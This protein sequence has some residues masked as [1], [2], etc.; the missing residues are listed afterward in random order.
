MKNA[1][2]YFNGHVVQSTKFEKIELSDSGLTLFLTIGY[3]DSKKIV[4]VIPTTHLIII[5]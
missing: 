4:A 5:N 2:I 1:E 3:G